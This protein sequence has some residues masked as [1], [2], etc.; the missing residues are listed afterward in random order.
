MFV[1]IYSI[2]I[3][4]SKAIIIALRRWFIEMS[5]WPQL[6]TVVCCV[7]HHTTSSIFFHPT[8]FPSD[9]KLICITFPIN[10]LYHNL[11]VSNCDYVMNPIRYP[12]PSRGNNFKFFMWFWACVSFWHAQSDMYR[13]SEM[14][15]FLLGWWWLEGRVYGS[16]IKQFLLFTTKC[17][18]IVHSIQSNKSKPEAR[19]STVCSFQS[20]VELEIE[21]HNSPLS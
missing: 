19:L 3:K 9:I 17:Y 5:T 16:E 14:R 15:I 18:I 6:Y 13:S 8:D 21:A 11:V 7:A 1:I 4:H 2:Q 10:S 12:T 20:L